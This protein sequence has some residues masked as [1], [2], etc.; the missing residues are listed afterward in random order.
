MGTQLLTQE[1]R[2]IFEDIL[3]TKITT[4]KSAICE[5]MVFCMDHANSSGQIVLTI[6]D[7]FDEAENDDLDVLVNLLKNE[8]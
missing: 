3:K 1:E 5:S 4:Q 6:A 7:A 2:D 8:N